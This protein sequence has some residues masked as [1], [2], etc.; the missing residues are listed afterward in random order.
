MMIAEISVGDISTVHDLAH[1]RQHLVMENLAMFDDSDQCFL[2]CHVRKNSPTVKVIPRV[3][4]CGAHA[5]R[6]KLAEQLV[7]LFGQ[8]RLRMELYA[9]HR[10][11]LVPHTHDF[12]IVGPRSHFEAGG[13]ALLVDDKR[14][15]ARGGKRIRQPVKNTGILVADVG[16]SSRASVVPH[17]RFFRQTPVRC[18][19]G[20][21][22]HRGSAICLQRRL[23]SG[24]EMPA[25]LGVH[26]PGEITILDGM[27]RFDLLE[28]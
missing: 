7:A 2:G 5:V 19:G 6:K 26:G 4:R 12:P 1:Q 23:M 27:Q 24:T 16:K 10:Q 3:P 18:F 20:P 13:N 15:I 8:D 17:E 22:R 11:V 14:M 9:L 21:S 28:R 25:S